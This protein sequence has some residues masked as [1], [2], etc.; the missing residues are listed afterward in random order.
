MNRPIT[1][2][3]LDDLAVDTLR[4]VGPKMAGRLANMHIHTVQDLL[5]HLPLRYQDR[6]RV[7]SIA[8]LAPGQ[9]ALIEGEVRGTGIVNGRRRSM[10]C[11]LVDHSGALTLRFFHF[12]PQ[13]QDQLRPGARL[14]CYGEV[15]HGASGLEIYHPEYRRA[16]QRANAGPVRDARAGPA[17]SRPPRAWSTTRY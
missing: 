17:R 15:R 9:E 12:G 8:H 3:T 16:D 1:T 7:R 6:T 2:A 10:T 5:F 11:Q 4:G 14:R 13:Q